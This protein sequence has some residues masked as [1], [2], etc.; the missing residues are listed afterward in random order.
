MS[1]SDS[2]FGEALPISLMLA[3]DLDLVITM[4]IIRYSI[5]DECTFAPIK[6][7]R[8]DVYFKFT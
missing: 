3:S 4:L 2:D 6:C 8:L 7:Q 5:M 1:E